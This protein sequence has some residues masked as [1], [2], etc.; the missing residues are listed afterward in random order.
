MMTYRSARIVGDGPA[1]LVAAL[2]LV[3]QGWRVDVTAPQWRR[4]ARRPD[5]I[6]VLGGSA[7]SVLERLGIPPR[8]LLAV[9]TPCPGRW[10]RWSEEAHEVDHFR[11]FETA[12]AVTRPGFDALLA[13]RA[14]AAGVRFSGPEGDAS[15]E[16]SRCSWTILATGSGEETKGAAADERL[17]AFVMT[18]ALDPADGAV[19]A[20]L[21]VE[22]CPEGWAYAAICRMRACV[23][24][25]TD[26]EALRRSAIAPRFFVARMLGGT[27]RIAGISKRL[28][29]GVSMR[30]HHFAC[31]RR[32]LLA[33][34]RL[35]R[36]G[37]ARMTLDPLAGRGLWEAVHGTDRVMAAILDN[38]PER[39]VD[40]EAL[41]DDT[42][43][44]YLRQRWAFY[45]MLRERFGT[46]FWVRRYRQRDNGSGRP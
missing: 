7:L 9:A 43:R 11:T 2:A 35:V 39:L 23:G 18:G 27:A 19:D 32:P 33:A 36:V 12:W 42:Y 26:I 14:V 45:G 13:E 37:D 4:A 29:D 31:G 34:E 25:V 5:R 38:A 1:G 6:D 20:R 8:D 40:E 22:A 41:A 30:G 24:V 21:M 10:T 15:T 28:G 17:V 46:G 44:S 3:Q 16:R